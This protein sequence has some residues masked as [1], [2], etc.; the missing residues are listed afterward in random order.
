[1][2]PGGEDHDRAGLVDRRDH[3]VVPLRAARLDD[4]GD[5]RLERE[6]RAV[7]EGE[8]PVRG[9]DGAGEVVAELH[10]LVERDADGVDPA[11]LAG[12]D[13]ERL[14]PVGDHDRVRE[15]VLGDAPGE[16]QVAPGLLVG[17]ACRDDAHAL[18]VVDVGVR[19]LHE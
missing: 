9:Q 1:M 5:P 14:Q 15:H 7:R 3:L 16:E 2:A 12:P 4:G 10:G 6:L 8:E 19:I 11:H 13:A 17:S 18:A